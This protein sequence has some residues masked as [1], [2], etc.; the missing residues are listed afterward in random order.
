MDEQDQAPLQLRHWIAQLDPRE[1]AQVR[2]AV[3]YAER[4]TAAGAPGHGQ[5]LLIAKMAALLDARPDPDPQLRIQKVQFDQQTQ[6]W[7]DIVTG[8]KVDVK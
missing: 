7:R 1:L 4:H 6:S 5:F 2:H 3:V 8:V